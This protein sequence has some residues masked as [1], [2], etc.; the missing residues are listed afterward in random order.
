MR[1]LYWKIVLIEGLFLALIMGAAVWFLGMSHDEFETQRKEDRAAAIQYLRITLQSGLSPEVSLPSLEKVAGRML[2]SDV[3]IVEPG[4]ASDFPEQD[5]IQF[6]QAGKPYTLLLYAPTHHKGDRGKGGFPLVD[7]KY[8]IPLLVLAATLGLLAIPL[9]RIVTRP[10]SELSGDMKRFASGDLAHRT[11]VESRDEVGDVAKDFNEM[12]ES[13]QSLVRV[14]KEMTAHVSHELR[15]PLTRIDVTRQV[16]EEQLTGKPLAL[17]ASMGEEI[18]GMDVL[19]DRILR[20]SRL[21]LNE[22]SPAPLCYVEI[23]QE[24][25][26][27]HKSSFKAKGIP[28]QTDF[29]E[30]LPGVGVADDVACLVDNLLNNALKFTPPKGN[31]TVALRRESGNA[32]IR[33]INTADKPA[34]DPARLSE[35]FQR[36]GASEA[37]PGSGL[38]LAIARRIVENHGGE[39][40]LAWSEGRFSAVITLPL[41]KEDT[42][43]QG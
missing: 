1:R 43:G 18:R 11:K 10:L 29:P 38:G 5:K 4:T 34:L 40:A 17:L 31:T 37:I 22:S 2:K 13:I 33:V 16:L 19:I 20:L 21:E 24:A 42:P 30:S 32:M 39:M 27:R 7:D 35:A 15:S 12:A 41:R 25:V 3:R 6:I 36:G 26:R 28:L 23:L 8:A 9:A 14:G